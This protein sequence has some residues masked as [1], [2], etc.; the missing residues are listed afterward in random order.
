MDFFDF[1]FFLNVLL[2][3]LY[4]HLMIWTPLDDMA[5]YDMDPYD[6]D[7]L[8]MCIPSKFD[9]WTHGNNIN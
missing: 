2:I 4:F 8:V 1:K 7:P 3:T 5:S 6:M 9:T